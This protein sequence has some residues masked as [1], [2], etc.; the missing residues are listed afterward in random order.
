MGMAW[1][2]EVDSLEIV[3]AWVFELVMGF[4]GL[5]FAW[6]FVFDSGCWFAWGF[7]SQMVALGCM[8]LL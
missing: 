8:L 5:G 6:V 3:L 2:C 4:V 1:P 7:G